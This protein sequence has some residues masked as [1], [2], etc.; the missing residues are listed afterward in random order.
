[1]VVF[2]SSPSYILQ[3]ERFKMPTW[4]RLVE[5]IK[6]DMVEKNPALA[7]AIANDHLGKLRLGLGVGISIVYYFYCDL[8]NIH[9]YA[10]SCRSENYMN[11]ILVCNDYA[12]CNNVYA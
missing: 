6:D 3:V 5:A 9:A 2:Y 12:Q 7:Q 8:W 1:M 11:C 4:S 10:K